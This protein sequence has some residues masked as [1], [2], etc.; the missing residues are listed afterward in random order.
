MLGWG[1]SVRVVTTTRRRSIF[2][3]LPPCVDGIKRKNC[4]LIV[5]TV[6]VLGVGSQWGVDKDV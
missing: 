3:H 1:L 5:C 4:V 2:K 6:G